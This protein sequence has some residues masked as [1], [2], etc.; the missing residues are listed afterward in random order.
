M[1]AQEQR[2]Y[3]YPWSYPTSGRRRVPEASGG[4]R[5]RQLGLYVSLRAVTSTISWGFPVVQ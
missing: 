1:S 5:G 2:L 3:V 4:H